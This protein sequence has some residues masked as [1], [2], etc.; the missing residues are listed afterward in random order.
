[1]RIPHIFL[2][3]I[4]ALTVANASAADPSLGFIFH[5]E[6]A[7]V[8]AAPAAS[9]Q[10]NAL[11]AMTVVPSGE[12]RLM[13]QT[14]VP[15]GVEMT[16]QTAQADT[17]LSGGDPEINTRGLLPV[18]LFE[19]KD[20]VAGGAQVS[21]AAAQVEVAPGVSDAPYVVR[22][23]QALLGSIPHIGGKSIKQLIASSPIHAPVEGLPEAYWKEEKCTNCHEWKEANLCDQAAFYTTAKGEGNMSKKHPYGGELKKVLRDWALGDCQ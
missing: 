12:D 7:Y 20:E 14:V 3:S 18:K 5:Q 11:M 15:D 17:S 13:V 8:H 16:F 22:F 9:P 1:M 23:D 6:P 10:E 2:A 19:V 4:A 21:L